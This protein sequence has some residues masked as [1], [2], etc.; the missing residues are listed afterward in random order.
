[1]WAQ[2]GKEKIDD[3]YFE[4]DYV[5]LFLLTGKEKQYL[6]KNVISII[7]HFSLMKCRKTKDLLFILTEK[8]GNFLSFLCLKWMSMFHTKCAYISVLV[9]WK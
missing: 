8:C 2:Q 3:D 9:L 5:K 6:N 1:M 7:H 4:K